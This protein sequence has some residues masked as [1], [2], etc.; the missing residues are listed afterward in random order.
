MT[1]FELEKCLDSM[2]LL[3][4]TREQP[5]QKL[6]ARIETSGLPYERQKLEQGDY[7]CKC[8]LPGGEELDFSSRV[9]IERKMNLDELC[10]CFGKER[11][12][13]ER[14][15]ERAKEA[16][17]KIYLLV[18]GGSWE[19]VYNGKYRSQYNQ[20]ALVASIDAF[21]ARYGMQLDF[22]KEETSGKLI[23]DILYRELKEH[24]QGLGE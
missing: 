2:V 19:K 6:K 18:E 24:L 20:K 11:K 9:A 5:T 3:V 21:R 10:L 13:F 14:E 15:F 22:C 12:R 17:C 23:K 8:T 7:S 1:P 16:G 4:D